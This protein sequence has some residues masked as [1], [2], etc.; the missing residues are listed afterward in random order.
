MAT[1][2]LPFRFLCIAIFILAGIPRLNFSLGPI[3][4][5]MVDVC[6]V[7][8]IYFGGLRRTELPFPALHGGLALTILSFAIVSELLGMFYSGAWVQTA[9]MT[10]RTC[11]AVSFFFLTNNLVRN[12]DELQALL[13]YAVC[14]MM[15]SATLMIMTSLP[16]TRGSVAWLFSLNFLSPVGERFF[17]QH[18]EITRGVRGQSLVG[19]NIISAWFVCLIW[20]LSICLYRSPHTLGMWKTFARVAMIAAP[21]GIIF[22]YSRGAILGLLLIITVL[23]LFGEGRLKTQI[24]SAVLIVTGI[25]ATFGWDS[26]LFYFERLERRT[27][28]TFQNPMESRMESERFGSYADALNLVS[29]EPIIGIIGEGITIDRIRKRGNRTAKSILNSQK[30]NMADHSVFAQG[31]KKYGMIAA[32]TYLLLLALSI[33]SG[34]REANVSRLSEGLSR[35]FPQLAFAGVFGLS[36]W[37]AFDKGIIIQPRGAMLFFFTISLIGVCQNLRM[38]AWNRSQE[39]DE[40][41]E[42]S[43]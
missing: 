27:V 42:V 3:P 24:A 28:A 31:T 29:D 33:I 22:S 18:A 1:Q 9:Y 13:K 37:V 34:Y 14:G 16:G 7:G 20:P 41:E 17:E 12:E 30:A 11:L 43:K 32:T 40:L 25:I 6:L 26:D 23:L 2:N 8:A 15:I 39:L 5:Y 19:Y 10:M 21:F 36:A 4:V 35:Y 38:D